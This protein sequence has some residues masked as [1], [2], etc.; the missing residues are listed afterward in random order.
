VLFLDLDRFKVINDSL[1]HP[2]GDELLRTFADRIANDLRE[3]DT[4]SRFGGDEFI[5]I[6]QD[7]DDTSDA[8]RVASRIMDLVKEPFLIK[9]HVVYTTASIGIVVG[10]ARYDKPEQVLRDADIAMFRA[11]N[12]WQSGYAVF[13]EEMHKKAVHLLKLESELRRAINQEEFVLHYQPILSL[14]TGKINGY[15][16]LIRWSHP[17]HGLIPPN[18]FIPLAE[19]TGLIIP[20]GY[21]VIQEA[22][23]QMAEWQTTYP[24]YPRLVISVNLSGL[25]LKDRGL[26][27]RIRHT[28]EETPLEPEYLAL[29]ITESSIIDD[30]KTVTETLME[31]KEMGVRLHMDD[32]GA[33]YSSLNVLYNLP[34]D[35]IKID[36]S[37]VQNMETEQKTVEIVKTIIRLGQNMGKDVIAEGIESVKT[38][39]ILRELGSSYGQG[40][41]FSKPK[42]PHAFAEELHT[43][44][45]PLRA[46]KLYFSQ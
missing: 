32:F 7:I 14:S 17:E 35:T 12:E 20:I 37:F 15:E 3:V 39:S 31:L 42:E 5:I 34:I 16:A 1:G 26:C 41:L 40:Y 4:I 2:I 10:D 46:L 29:E 9:D 8:I 11:K 22:C 6:M 25:Q 36:G 24:R 23:R 43:G 33:G 21:W 19:E 44:T 30:F 18:E 27:K 38:L 28:L 45:A 13:D